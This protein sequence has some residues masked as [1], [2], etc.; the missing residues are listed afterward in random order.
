MNLEEKIKKLD[1]QRQELKK[2]LEERE[3]SLTNGGRDYQQYSVLKLYPVLRKKE[4]TLEALNS[5]V[6]GLNEKLSAHYLLESKGYDVE[7]IEQ[8]APEMIQY[9]V[10]AKRSKS[11]TDVKVDLESKTL[12]LLLNYS[13]HSGS[14]GCEYGKTLEV[15][16]GHSSTSKN[17][18]Y[19][20]AC[21]SS[22]DDWSLAFDK[23]ESLEVEEDDV[24]IK[25]KTKSVGRE[26][27]LS[28]KM[29]YEK[30]GVNLS[31]EEKEAFLK[32]YQ[33]KKEELLNIH[34]RDA[35]MMKIYVPFDSVPEMGGKEIPYQKAET[36][37]E[38]VDDAKGE[39]TLVIKSQIDHHAGNGMQFEWVKYKISTLGG[40]RIN[41]DMIITEMIDR[42]CAYESELKRGKEIKMK[43]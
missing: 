36:I 10:R 7:A 16:R 30:Q 11:I 27:D 22:R 6:R 17:F 2:E 34:T 20:D 4:E 31:E 38:F 25:L 5:I 13:Y 42:D 39:A 9:I 15:H 23:I 21:S 32:T 24:Q 8:Q 41:T 33:A 18:V 40:D 3:F 29:K 35:G 12:A 1:K 19:R 26:E 37:D 14:G 28:F 43:A